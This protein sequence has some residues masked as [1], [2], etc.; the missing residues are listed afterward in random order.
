M[1][2]EQLAELAAVAGGLGAAAVLLA[3]SRLPLLAGF[4]MLAAAEA[5]LLAARVPR[6][7]LDRLTTPLA[8]AALTAAL[9][10]GIALAAVFVRRPEIVPVVLLVAA[11]FRLPV[12]LGAQ[13]AFLLLPLY[14]VLA[15]TVLALLY[16]AFRD[17]VP[18]IRPR[19]GVP[20]AAFIGFSALSLS[21]SLDPKQGT[22]ELL[23]FLF[24]AAALVAVVARAPLAPWLARALA[25]TLVALASFFA[26]VGLW[27]E[28]THRIFFARDLEVANAYTTYFRVTSLFKDPS[29]FGRHLVLAI[30][31]LVVALWLQRVHVAVVAVCSAL[32]FAGLWFSYSQSSMATLFVVAVAI[33]L[34]LADREA[35]IAVA[36][37]C[38]ALALVAAVVVTATA[39][40]NPLR[41]VTSGRS[42]LAEITLPVIRNHPV[43]GAGVGAQPLA[44]REE[45]DTE[46]RTSRN[47]SHTTPLTVA[48]ELGVLGLLA[49]LALLAGGTRLVMETIT[50]D[51]TFGMGLAAVLL[52]L[53]LHS[54]VYAGFFEDPIAWGA[55][56]LAAAAA[57]APL[58]A[59]G[60]GTTPWARRAREA[61]DGRAARTIRTAR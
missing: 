6:E 48:A 8:V 32:L 51:R 28:A 46:T 12:D 53:F 5:G 56:A 21:W 38:V 13:H 7:D 45:A 35:R 4:A 1:P 25:V 3:R 36:A 44:S 47:A 29:L 15:A 49:Y 26:L 33:T 39:E 42:H 16:R 54:L 20:A 27:Q 34:A 40:S 50:R 9:L 30:A 58:G 31:V 10:A 19:L 59:D 41:K 22:I 17:D 11:P 60:L 55:V 18:A 61:R 57:S 23:F 2:H 37:A 52:T 24:P 43:A 14:G